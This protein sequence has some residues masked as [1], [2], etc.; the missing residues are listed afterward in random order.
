MT[1]NL[2][3]V[4]AQRTLFAIGGLQSALSNLR[5]GCMTSTRNSAR[6]LSLR[7]QMSSSDGH[8]REPWWFAPML[9]AGICMAVAALVLADLIASWLA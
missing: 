1:Q 5:E 2:S 6:G 4:L 7:P 9:Y 3:S 8:D